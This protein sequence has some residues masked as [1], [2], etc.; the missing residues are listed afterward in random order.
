MSHSHV[1]NPLLKGIAG[2]PP[3]HVLLP[4]KCV[5]NR[6]KTCPCDGYAGLS[7]RPVD[8]AWKPKCKRLRTFPF[9]QSGKIASGTS[10]FKWVII[11]CATCVCSA[12]S[13][14][15]VSCDP[16]KTGCT[17]RST[18]CGSFRFTGNHIP[19]FNA[20]ATATSDHEM[21]GSRLSGSFGFKFHVHSLSHDN[22]E[23]ITCCPQAESTN[24]S[25]QKRTTH[26]ARLLPSEFSRIWTL[27]NLSEVTHQSPIWNIWYKGKLRRLTSKCS[28]YTAELTTIWFA[29]TDT[30]YSWS[31]NV[32][33]YW[34]ILDPIPDIAY[35]KEGRHRSVL[36][37]YQRDILSTAR[38]SLRRITSSFSELLCRTQN[39]ESRSESFL[40]RALE[41]HHL[42]DLRRIVPSHSFGLK[43]YWKISALMQELPMPPS[44]TMQKSFPLKQSYGPDVEARFG[45][46]TS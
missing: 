25:I 43:A 39:V 21:P 14:A 20:I 5:D 38:S 2:R 3:N 33:V 40:Y 32:S 6:S 11:A 22:V 17:T 37:T 31:K 23:C 24:Q 34:H 4:M 12:R 18:P 45:S 36:A 46:L 1:W 28:S 8:H 27:Y 42:E 10:A 26:A 30:G 44:S 15:I 35:I 9:L 29:G 19:C 16:W 13:V 7:L 41:C